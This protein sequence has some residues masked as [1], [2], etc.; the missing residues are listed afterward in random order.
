MAVNIITWNV[1]GLN[2]TLMR[3]LVLD[4]LKPTMLTMIC[5]MKTHL[6]GSRI[7]A[8]KHPWIGWSY[9]ASWLPFK[10]L[11]IH[12]AARERYLFLTCLAGQLEL[13]LA[14][15][16]IKPPYSDECIQEW[17]KCLAD[18]LRS[19]PITAGDFCSQPHSRQSAPRRFLGGE[20]ASNLQSLMQELG[21]I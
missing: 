19:I 9:H 13:L 12:T 1:K 4:F 5:S 15:I 11:H 18:Y 3:R 8:L 2:N 17:A 16:Y 7:L 10:M 21:L 6:V 20:V 14:N